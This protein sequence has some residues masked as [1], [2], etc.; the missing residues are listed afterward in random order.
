MPLRSTARRPEHWRDPLSPAR[1]RHLR[2]WFAAGA[3]L[4][5]LIV[6]VGGITR[7]TQSGLS[8]VDWN[9]V[10]G[11]IPPLGEGEWAAAFER[12]QQ[13]PEYRQLR[14]DMSLAEFKFI[15]FWEYTH[16]LLARL[17]GIVFLVP[18][19]VFA[20]RGYFRGPLLRRVL[21]LFVLGG[22]QGFVG[23]FMVRSGLVDDPRVSHYRLA[24]HLAMALS[25]LA[26][27]TWLYLETREPAGPAVATGPRRWVYAL[28]ALLGAQIAY[29]AFVAGLDAGLGFNTFPLMGGRWFPHGGLSLDP[30]WRNAVANPW[31]VQWVH[32]VLGTVLLIAALAAWLRLRRGSVDARS[33]RLAGAFLAL[34]AVQFTLGIATLL[35]SVPVSLGVL[36]QATAVVVFAV[37]L[38]WLHHVRA[39]PAAAPPA[40]ADVPSAATHPGTTRELAPSRTRV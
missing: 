2:V 13:F 14:P 20:A 33:R 40:R 38:T 9:P 36:H 37:W 29:G 34:L 4:T 26:L 35:L 16:R 17:I 3:T 19:A 11:A 28:G 25:I 15:F 5:F 24:L 18:F 30:V 6:V 10:M 21:L 27:C 31:T 1:R 8:I 39:R 23:W 32:R 22:L 7:L 12:Y